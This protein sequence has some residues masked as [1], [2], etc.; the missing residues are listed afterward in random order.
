MYCLAC[1]ASGETYMHGR[2]LPALGRR[3][4]VALCLAS[5]F[6]ANMCDFFAHDLGLGHVRGLPFLAATFAAVLAAERFD[7]LAHESH[8]WLPI[9]TVRTAPTILADFMAGSKTLPRTPLM[10]ALTRFFAV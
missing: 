6:G 2:H 10:V 7:R 9:V 1:G 8:Y 3:F 4:W 5:I